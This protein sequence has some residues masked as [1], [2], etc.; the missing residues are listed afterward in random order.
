VTTLLYIILLSYQLLY[1]VQYVGH[2]MVILTFF[3][4]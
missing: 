2:D 1:S 4:N 3:A